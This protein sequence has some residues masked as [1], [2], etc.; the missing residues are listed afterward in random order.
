MTF[1]ALNSNKLN[2][3][4]SSYEAKAYKSKFIDN[5]PIIW[6]FNKKVPS[7]MTLRMLTNLHIVCS[8]SLR[9]A[10]PLKIPKIVICHPGNPWALYSY[11][12]K[13]VSTWKNNPA[14]NIFTFQSNALPQIFNKLHY[15]FLN[16]QN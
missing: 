11:H 4:Q 5:F 1:D 6:N 12:S 13:T 9:F 15:Q 16:S 3:I 2:I 8:K 10:Y 7:R 14:V